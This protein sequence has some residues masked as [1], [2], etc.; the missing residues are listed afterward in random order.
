MFFKS[1]YMKQEMTDPLWVYNLLC[2]YPN[3]VVFNI[4]LM[5]MGLHN[6][7]LGV[8]KEIYLNFTVNIHSYLLL[9]DKREGGGY[10]RLIVPAD[11][12]Y[13]NR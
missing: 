10:N 6:I 9:M 8:Q 1:N 7:V 13:R 2:P 4:Y 12:S 11:S 3:T 5:I